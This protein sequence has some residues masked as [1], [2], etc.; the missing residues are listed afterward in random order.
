MRARFETKKGSDALPEPFTHPTC[1]TTLHMF[2]KTGSG[3]TSH[4]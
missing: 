2:L 3:H 1:Y 4:T